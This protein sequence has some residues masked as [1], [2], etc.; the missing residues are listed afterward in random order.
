MIAALLDPNAAE[1]PET[2]ARLLNKLGAAHRQSLFPIHFTQVVLPKIGGHIALFT[3]DATVGAVEMGVGFLFP[4]RL[5]RKRPAF[6][7]RYHELANGPPID[8]TH[9]VGVA[10]S[11]LNNASVT[12]Y[13][14][15]VDHAFTQ[16]HTEVNGIDIGLPS[17]IEAVAA[18]QI[19]QQVW[20]SSEELLYPTDIYSDDFPLGTSLMARVDGE[21]VGFLF[22]FYKIGSSTLPVD[23]VER[24][25]GRRRIESQ[26][27]GIL[28][29]YRGRR[30]G[31]LL[32]WM[33][34]KR[35]REEGI[36]IVNWTV[37]P[38]QFANAALN[39]GLLRAVAF[40]FHADLYPFRNELN[41]VAA[42]RFG[43]TWLVGSERVRG[44]QA[45]GTEAQIVDLA[46]EP[47][48]R[49]IELESTQT[50]FA[51]DDARIAI[52]IPANWTAL[53]QR[54]IVA[55]QRL[56][57]STDSLFS[58]IIGCGEGKY[59]ITGVGVNADRRYLIAERASE[60]LWERLQG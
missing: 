54:D 15:T 29:A 22:G 45:T 53:Q 17:A 39:F 3:E 11:L 34:A 60:A 40:D 5:D 20:K 37:D 30:I 18:R 59:A 56:R 25:D 2:V 14:H 9:L 42:S 7:L 28:P 33:Q 49:T 6:V 24:L 26:A 27:M 47:K 35:A 31:Y 44:L 51:F 36:Q 13:D 10:R 55:A 19:Q 1:W 46:Q 21:V 16:T 50:G 43:I 52:E 38:L 58:H 8:P 4:D 41:Q 12:L 57:Q 23:W 32:K 48:M